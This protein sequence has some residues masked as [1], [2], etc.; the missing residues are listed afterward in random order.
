MKLCHAA[1]SAL[2]AWLMMPPLDSGL[3]DSAVVR[4]ATR[5]KCAPDARAQ[6]TPR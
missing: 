4:G 2:V 6:R 1:A 5:I 3:S